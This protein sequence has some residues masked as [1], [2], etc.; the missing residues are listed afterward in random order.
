VRPLDRAAIINDAVI[1]LR[2]VL[3]LRARAVPAAA[4]VVCRSL[5]KHPPCVLDPH[6]IGDA[7]PQG[8]S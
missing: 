5:A 8:T 2:L 1:S 3:Q 6:F 4:A 7:G